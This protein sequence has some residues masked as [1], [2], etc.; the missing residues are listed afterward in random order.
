M[1]FA[2]IKF[3]VLK[4]PSEEGIITAI[5]NMEK[6]QLGDFNRTAVPF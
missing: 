2:N 3:L 6:L 5:L 1:N 4:K